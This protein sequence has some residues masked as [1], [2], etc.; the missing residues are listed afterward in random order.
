MLLREL[1]CYK[2]VQFHP[3]TLAEYLA[4]CVSYVI[5]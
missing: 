3:I 2:W 4:Y 1:W 5:K